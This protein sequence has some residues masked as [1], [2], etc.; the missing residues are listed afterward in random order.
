MNPSR[1]TK[2]LNSVVASLR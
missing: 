2:L 1:N